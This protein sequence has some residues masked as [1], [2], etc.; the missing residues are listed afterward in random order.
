MA[1]TPVSIDVPTLVVDRIS[2][3]SGV[4]MTDLEEEHELGTDLAMKHAQFVQLAESLRAIVKLFNKKGS[5]V[6][7]DVEDGEA[8]VKSTI[9]LVEERAKP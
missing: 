4:L 7:G 1:N 8:T 2:R 5:V 6:V 3:F 9:A